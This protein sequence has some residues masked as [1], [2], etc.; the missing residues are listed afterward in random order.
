MFLIVLIIIKKQGLASFLVLHGDNLALAWL[1]SRSDWSVFKAEVMAGLLANIPFSS[2]CCTVFPR[3]LRAFWLFS[4]KKKKKKRA[5][6]PSW[7]W[8]PSCFLVESRL[9]TVVLGAGAVPRLRAW[10]W[11]H[12]ARLLS[13]TE[14]PAMPE[15][16]EPPSPTSAEGTDLCRKGD[17]IIC[18]NWGTNQIDTPNIQGIKSSFVHS[19]RLTSLLPSEELVKEQ[20]EWAAKHLLVAVMVNWGAEV[21]TKD[22]KLHVEGC[23]P[24]FWLS[25]QHGEGCF[26]L[27]S[28]E[29]LLI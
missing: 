13:T 28:G 21:K 8:K 4:G 6:G 26:D 22:A 12:S 1:L 18:A 20:W 27:W 23:Q 7:A 29:K 5:K 10:V 25:C 16:T 2:T 11:L 19:E 15:G 3:H 14:A 24:Y 17:L 9:F